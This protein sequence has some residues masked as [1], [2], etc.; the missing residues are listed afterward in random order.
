MMTY[1]SKLLNTGLALLMAGL[2]ATAVVL[3]RNHFVSAN[4]NVEISFDRELRLQGRHLR[5]ELERQEIELFSQAEHPLPLE[6]DASVIV[7]EASFFMIFGDRVLPACTAGLVESVSAKEANEAFQKGLA[8]L[9]DKSALP[10][11]KI[12]E[13]LKVKTAD[14]LYRKIGAWFNVLEFEQDARSVCC[15]LSLINQSTPTLTES[16]RS[17]FNGMLEEQEPNLDHIAV[18]LDQQLATAERIDKNLTRQKG[19]YRTAFNGHTLSV[20][21]DGLAVLYSPGLETVPPVELTR[22]SE[23]NLGMEIAPELYATIPTAIVAEAQ[24]NI[25]RQYRTGNMIL[26]LMALLGTGL[27]A[28]M[29]ASAKR[30]KKLDSLRTQ[31]IATVSHELRTPLSL[32]RLHAETLK[33]GRVPA[34]KVAD[35]HQTILT[36]AE[37]LTGIVNN[38]L[39]FS[40]MERDKLQIHPEPTD[41][42]ALVHRIA[43]SF[44]DRLEQEGFAFEREIAEDVA[45]NV[46]PLAYSQIVF[47]LLDNAIKYSDRS[48]TVRIELDAATDCATL[49]VVDWGIGIPDPLKKHIFDEFVR[50]DDSRVTARRGSGIGLSVAKRLAERMNGTIEV[51][52]NE[53]QGSVFTVQLIK[54]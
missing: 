10:H 8:A 29:T 6:D 14:D 31:F 22:S 15:L 28:G 19:A 38:V 12:A 30:R 2:F 4:A 49:R 16:Q 54:E 11:F 7:D 9:P 41:L 39:D 3:N 42:S 18:W 1:L 20:R 25:L 53:P 23:G 46:D 26:A 51:T 50:S 34:G 37:R 21:E 32:I 35:Y 52:D 24:L 43:D 44:G 13:K 47:N 48:K 45:A 33:H 27:L 5:K 17:F 36:E 40:R